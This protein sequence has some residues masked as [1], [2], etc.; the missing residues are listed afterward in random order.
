MNTVTEGVAIAVD[1]L[2]KSETPEIVL[3]TTRDTSRERVNALLRA[4][5]LSALHNIRQVIRVSSI[6]LLGSGKT[7]Y[8]TLRAS[9]SSS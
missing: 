4:A 8:R 5:G 6:P 2:G 3:F 7:D 1:A 9:S